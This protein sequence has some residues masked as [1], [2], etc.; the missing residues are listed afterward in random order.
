MQDFPFLI[1]CRSKNTTPL[2]YSDKN[3]WQDIMI[4]KCE[5]CGGKRIFEF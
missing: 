5:A 4:N 3:I 1:Y 2:W